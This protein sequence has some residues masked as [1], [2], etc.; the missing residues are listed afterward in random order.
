MR[1]AQL[2]QCSRSPLRDE[3]AYIFS[4][5]ERWTSEVLSQ[6]QESRTLS[7]TNATDLYKLKLPY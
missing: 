7:L 3:Y 2:L 1:F 5:R 6:N 4:F